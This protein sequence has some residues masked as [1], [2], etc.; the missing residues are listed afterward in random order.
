MAYNPSALTLSVDSIAGGSLRIHFYSTSDAL[1]SVTASQY[2]VR[3]ADQGVRLG[4]L[5]VFKVPEGTYLSQVT[6]VTAAGNATVVTEDAT[7]DINGGEIDG[8]PI[9]ADVPST[10]AFTTL[11]ST[12]NATIGGTTLSVGGQEVIYIPT[13]SNFAD[14][15]LYVGDGGRNSTWVSGLDGRY[16]TT[17][18]FRCGTAITTASYT[19]AMGFETLEQLTTGSYNSAFGEAAGIYTTTGHS[20]SFFGWKAGLGREADTGTWYLN[21]FIGYGSGLD[22][23]DGANNNVAV[24]PNTMSNSGVSAGLSGQFNNA[25]GS[26]A[27]NGIEGG[28]NNNSFGYNTLANVSTGNSNIGVG[29]NT[30]GGITTG[31]FNVIIGGALNSLSATLAQNIIIGDGAGIPRFWVTTTSTQFTGGTSTAP[32]VYFEVIN[33]VATPVNWAVMRPAAT[34][35]DILISPSTDAASDAASNIMLQATTASTRRNVL[36]ITGLNSTDCTLSVIGGITA[37][38]APS[39]FNSAGG[40]MVGG[41]G[42]NAA[43]ATN[44]TVGHLL[45]PCCAGTPTGVP[46]GAGASAVGLIYD[47]TNNILYAYDGG[48]NA[49]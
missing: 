20:N 8:T 12:G 49:V 16:N 2:F 9:G 45:I 11:S 41:V 32:K 7:Q 21:T 35:G 27:L 29:N 38:R 3:A 13:N 42:T 23:R 48:W 31:S 44:A 37:S 47:T 1:A 39:I 26:A 33:N 36:R 22:T 46:V 5:I 17:H 28:N 43:L 40:T 4:D 24:G 25:F 10:G 15:A 6:A 34:G 18:G 30:G 14:S 19:T